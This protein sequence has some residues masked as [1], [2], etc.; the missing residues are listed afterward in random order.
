MCE[1]VDLNDRKKRED[2]ERRYQQCIK[3]FK[4]QLDVGYRLQQAECT[5]KC[6]VAKALRDAALR[7]IGH[8]EDWPTWAS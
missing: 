1:I 2:I 7:E 5:M 4:E 3:A 8:E 6:E